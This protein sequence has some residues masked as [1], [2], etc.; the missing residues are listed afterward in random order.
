M[1]AMND[2]D[3]A[4]FAAWSDL[5]PRLRNDPTE[6][7]RRLARRQLLTLTRP[8][9]AWCIALRATDTRMNTANACIVPE[10]ALDNPLSSV[11]VMGV[12]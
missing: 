12:I 9:R 1:A 8:P 4:I 7:A 5:L 2:L 3:A 10:D 6:L 11:P